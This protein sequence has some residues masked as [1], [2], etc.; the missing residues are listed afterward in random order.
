M[1]H[2]LHLVLIATSALLNTHHPLNPSISH[3]PF[4]HQRSLCSLQLRVSYGFSCLIFITLPY[5]GYL[6]MS[7]LQNELTLS[8]FTK[9]TLAESQD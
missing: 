6:I 9:A 1:I 7:M 8:N 4:L 3:P 2:H 5:V